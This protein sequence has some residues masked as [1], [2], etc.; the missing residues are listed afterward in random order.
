MGQIPTF[1]KGMV[2]QQEGSGLGLYLAQLIV[3][4]EKGYI[5]VASRVGQGSRF[6]LFLLN[7]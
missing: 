5:T 4:Q 2:E 7:A 3:L 6:S 1:Y